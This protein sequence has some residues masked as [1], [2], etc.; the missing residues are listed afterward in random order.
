MTKYFATWDNEWR[1]VRHQIPCAF[2]QCYQER[3]VANGLGRFSAIAGS[4]FEKRQPRL[5]GGAGIQHG[6]AVHTQ[7][8]GD[9]CGPAKPPVGPDCLATGAHDL[10]L[11]THTNESTDRDAGH[12]HCASVFLSGPTLTRLVARSKGGFRGAKSNAKADH[13]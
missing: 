10:S 11:S 12:A 8:V 5:A 1:I 13:V 7:G 2:L 4:E 9:P 6:R 3:A